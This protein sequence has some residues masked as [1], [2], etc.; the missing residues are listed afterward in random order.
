MD[1]ELT[2]T[3]YLP[4][5][6]YSLLAIIIAMLIT[7][8]YYIETRHVIRLSLKLPHP[9]RI[10]I[11]GHL[12]ITLK[13]NSEDALIC[14]VKLCAKYGSVLSLFYGTRAF[15][16]LT[17]PQDIEVILNN[18][19]HIDKPAE[20]RC[21]KPWLGD[22]ILFN[23]GA[24][25]LKE[26]Q[27]ILA[28]FRMQILRKCV[29]LFYEN[30][31]D[32]VR[33]LA[34]NINERFNCHEHLSVA[35]FNML[36]EAEM[37]IS[38][39]KIEDISFNYTTAVIKLSEIVHKRQIDMSLQSDLLFRFSKFA[40]LQQELLHTVHSAARLVIQEKWK[41]I[42]EKQ[43]KNKHQIEAENLTENAENGINTINYKMH[44]ARDDLDDIENVDMSEKKQLHFLEML[45]DMRKNGEMTDKEILNFVN[46]ILFAAHETIA[47]AS[48]FVLCT[49]G[50]LPEIQARVHDELDSI[51]YD[52]D[53]ECTFQ[54][55]INMK[56][57]DRVILETL[58]LFPVVPLFGRKL[59]KDA[60]I[61]NYVL[62]KD[63]IILIFPVVSHRTEKYYPN[64]LVFNPDNFL[65]DNMRQ[66]NSYAY[67]P[68]SAGPRS[69]LGRKYSMLTLKVLLSTLLRNYRITSDVS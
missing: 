39:K 33:R 16:F 20:Y 57:L 12:L 4:N 10:P 38:R 36:V 25:W 37:G 32:L 45:M 26:R 1:T 27:T 52:S 50:C 11:I 49:L 30:S 59:N 24:K 22:S 53:R 9:P 2:A 19:E 42:E 28:T 23:N 18:P 15:I 13:I 56:Y 67:I 48:S 61:G 41:D 14:F 46:S 29:P 62:P 5:I 44:Y 65:P 58:R 21:F 55:T 51:F 40:K 6:S 31:Q 66:R 63:A 8:H 60:R 7:L 35:T 47:A 54:D 64:P 69:C 34:Q 3:L 43:F 68:F 17:D